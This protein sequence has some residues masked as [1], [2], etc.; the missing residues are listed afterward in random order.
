MAGPRMMAGMAGGIII[1]FEG[2][3]KIFEWMFR[4]DRKY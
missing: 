2:V 3:I 4:I 1:I